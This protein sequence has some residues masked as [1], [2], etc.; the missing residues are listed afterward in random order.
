[1]SAGAGPGAGAGGGAGGGTAAVLSCTPP[2]GNAPR[3]ARGARM[4]VERGGAG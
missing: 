2:R 4:C 1:M 3:P